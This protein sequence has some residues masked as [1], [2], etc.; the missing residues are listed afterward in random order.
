M[1]VL[2]SRG[3]VI[4]LALVALAA[5]L[6][7]QRFLFG[8]ALGRSPVLWERL[9]GVVLLVVYAVAQAY[10]FRIARFGDRRHK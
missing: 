1:T 4:V 2:A 6:G 7:S 9:V 3:K 8:L 10:A 5:L